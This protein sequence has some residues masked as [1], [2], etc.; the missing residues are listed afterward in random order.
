[1][2]KSLTRNNICYK[3]PLLSAPN[4]YKISKRTL[5]S[6]IKRTVSKISQNHSAFPRVTTI[7][8]PYATYHIDKTTPQL[9]THELAKENPI[10]G[11]KGF[12]HPTFGKDLCIKQ[13]CEHKLCDQLCAPLKEKVLVGHGTHDGSREDSKFISTTDLNGAS[14]PQYMKSYLQPVHNPDTTGINIDSTKTTE[15]NNN[16]E[17]QENVHMHSSRNLAQPLNN[18]TND[19]TNIN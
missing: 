10:L 13:D 8:K 4:I 1:M 6:S 11:E 17:M 9:S 2:N 19:L 15:L 18:G 3:N 7:T 5:M 14:R 12:Q 16:K